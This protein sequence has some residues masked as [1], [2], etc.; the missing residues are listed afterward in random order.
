[1]YIKFS[2]NLKSNFFGQKGVCRGGGE[3]IIILVFLDPKS[4]E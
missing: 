2:I 3:G 1:M 4:L